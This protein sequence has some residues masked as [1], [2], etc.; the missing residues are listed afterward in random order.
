MIKMAVIYALIWISLSTSFEYL[1]SLVSVR[2]LEVILSPVHVFTSF[3]AIAQG[4]FAAAFVGPIAKISG[5]FATTGIIDQVLIF[6]VVELAFFGL[7]AGLTYEKSHNLMLSLILAFSVS[8]VSSLI[9]AYISK[10][11]FELSDFFFSFVNL[12]LLMTISLV[13]RKSLVKSIRNLKGG[14][15][16]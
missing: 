6:G 14:R 9:F 15:E 12:I 10:E 8:K 5:V 3:C 1:L 7:V 13:F 11:V 16:R 4:P 2:L